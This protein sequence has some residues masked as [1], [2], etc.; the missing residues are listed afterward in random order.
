MVLILKTLNS[1]IFVKTYCIQQQFTI[2][3]DPQQNFRIERFNDTII[4]SAK[5]LLNDVKLNKQF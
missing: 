5:V 2:P 1:M 4:N 3:Y